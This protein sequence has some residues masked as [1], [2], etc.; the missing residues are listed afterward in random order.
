[1]LKLAAQL[2]QL[3]ERTLSF[4]KDMPKMMF[5]APV[6]R[7]PTLL[8]SASAAQSDAQPSCSMISTVWAHVELLQGHVQ[9]DAESFCPVFPNAVAKSL[10][11]SKRCSSQ[12]LN[13]FY[14]LGAR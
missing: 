5:K 6:Q 12:L 2:F 9:N 1:M 14:C 4:Y 10:N 7:F 11:C 8:Q 13:D 3:S